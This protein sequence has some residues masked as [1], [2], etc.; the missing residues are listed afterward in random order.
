MKTT[1]LLLRFIPFFIALISLPFS[2]IAQ[3]TLIP[4]VNFE[5]KLTDFWY[6]T[7]GLNGNILNSDAGIVTILDLSQSN[8]SNLNGIEAFTALNYLYCDGNQLTNLNISENTALI[9]LFCEYNQLTSLDVSANTTLIELSCNSNQLTKLDISMNPDLTFLSCQENQILS[10]DAS[11]NM[12]LGYLDC[13]M[14]Q[15]ESLNIQNIILSNLVHCK[16][17]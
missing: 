8:V 11:A 1:I 16:V 13:S 4:Y 14:N 6:D 2:T 9:Q 5:Q 3:T 17:S 10:L 15:L 12:A 7:N